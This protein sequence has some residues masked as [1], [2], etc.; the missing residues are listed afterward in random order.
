MSGMDLAQLIE[1]SP[2]SS[3]YARPWWLDA[4]APGR[5]EYLTLEKGDDVQAAMPI[6]WKGRNIVMPPL[7][8]TL[9]ILFQPLQGSYATTTSARQ[10]LVTEMI[11]KIPPCH[12][13]SQQFNYNFT[14]WLP[15]YWDGFR[16]TT[17]YT[18]VI[19]DLSDLDAIWAAMDKTTRNEIRSAERELRVR[20]DVSLDD[21]HRLA[22]MGYVK[23]GRP[24][25]RE[26]VERIDAACVQNG[27]RE[28]LGAEAAA[29]ELE[30]V[31][32]MVHDRN[33][34]Y[35][36]LSGLSPELK[37]RGALSMVF[38]EGIRRMSYKVSCFDFEGSMLKDVQ[39][40]F[41]RFGAVQK[42]YS[43]IWKEDLVARI[44]ARLGVLRPL[45]RRVM[46][47]RSD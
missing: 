13:F 26:L 6:V 20:D 3:I 12:R 32:Y 41:L 18:Y 33:S 34:A 45:K 37:N 44:R 19:E 17:R 21:F 1:V 28:I 7:T 14:D 9:G 10:R 15:F 4:V 46:G 23:L 8:Q 2:Q 30:C 35:Y 24:Y 43:H 5:W 31:V 16:Q 38:W 27:A 42:P 25:P 36:L 11:D 22:R 47:D 39:R 40:K 29:G